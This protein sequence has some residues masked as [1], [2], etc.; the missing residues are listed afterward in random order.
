MYKPIVL[1]TNNPHKL[2]EYREILA[3]MGYVIYGTK[4]LNID[5]DPPE[6]GNTYEENAYIKAKALRNLVPY[7]VISDDSGLEIEALDNFPGIH[8]A[9]FAS[10]F[11]NYKEAME[12]IL[13]RMKDEENRNA[14][15]HCTICLLENKDSKP[16]FFTGIC[17]GKILDHIEGE[18][19]FGYDP[20]FQPEGYTETFAEMGNEEKN[21]ISHRA[22]AVQQ[23]VEYLRSEN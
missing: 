6:I 21:K 13:K 4:D 14:A 22:R 5:C 10:Q 20:I 3:P 1:A 11:K 15:F 12:E 19:G 8:S 18:H 16:L 2:Q 23:L 7:P 17:P 9:R